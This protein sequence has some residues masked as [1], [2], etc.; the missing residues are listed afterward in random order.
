MVHAYARSHTRA[1]TI[2]RT[3]H[4][5]GTRSHT[6]AY[7]ET[8]PPRGRRRSYVGVVRKLT[9]SGVVHGETR[10]LPPARAYTAATATSPP[11]TPPAGCTRTAATATLGCRP[12]AAC[13]RRCCCTAYS[14]LGLG[15]EGGGEGF[16]TVARC[17][18]NNTLNNNETQLHPLVRESSGLVHKL[19]A[20]P[21]TLPPP[22]PLPL[23]RRPILTARSPGNHREAHRG[24]ESRVTGMRKVTGAIKVPVVSEP[25]GD[26]R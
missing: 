13:L 26:P 18:N 23:L 17:A 4:A 10:R 20:L 22:P 15:S 12:A 25:T 9:W 24:D 19:T 2:S 14:C 8:A 16:F 3:R 11:V 21:A 6:G 5:R 7:A 1:H